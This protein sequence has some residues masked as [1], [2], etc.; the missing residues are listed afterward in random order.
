MGKLTQKQ[1]RKRRMVACPDDLWARFLLY[2][3][4][5]QCYGSGPYHA[6]IT[7]AATLIH[8]LDAVQDK[9]PSPPDT[10]ATYTE[11]GGYV[12]LWQRIAI[13]KEQAP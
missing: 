11:S 10:P 9:E 12:P 6:R 1:K 2:G 8:L 5:H 13:D 7:F 4:E 3:W